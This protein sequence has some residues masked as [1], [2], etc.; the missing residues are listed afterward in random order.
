MKPDFCV[1]EH[2]LVLLKPRLVPPYGWAGHIPFAYLAIDLL[3][4][5]IMVE[6]G[7]HSGNSYMAFCQA[8]QALDLD[9]RCT[10]VDAWQGD[11]HA[12]HYGEEVYQSLRA[13]HDPRYG[14]FSRLLR[15]RFGEAVGQ[16]ADGSI[17]LLHIDGLHTYEAVHHD[18][19]TWLPKLSE[20][21]VVLLHD[22]EERERDFGVGCFFD[23]LA[24]RYPCFAFRHSHGLG[25]VAVGTQL[26][27]AFAAFMRKVADAPQV[28]R[29]FF[30]ALASNLVDADDHLVGSTLAEAQQLSCHLFYRQR[31]ESFDESRMISLPLDAA[32]GVLDLQFRLP[33][34]ATPDYLRIDPADHPGVYELSRVALRQ[35]AD[36]DWHELDGLPSRLGHVHGEL[37]PAQTA[38][39]LRLV[40]FDDDPNLELEVGSA[41]PDRRS[42]EWLDVAVRV[43]YDVVIDDPAL[44]RLLECQ[45]ESLSGMVRLSRERIDVQ[46][47]SREFAGQKS[48]L[49]SL[50]G[51]FGRQRQALQ[52]HSSEFAQQRQQLQSLMD[53]FGQQRQALQDHSLEFAERRQ[54]LQHLMLGFAHQREQLQDLADTLGQQQAQLAEA[55][56]AKAEIEALTKQSVRQQADT[57]A[58]LQRLQQGIDS[59]AAQGFVAR[60]RR[61]LGRGR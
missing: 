40:S 4:P 8:V 27:E 51:E 54:Q 49:Q 29:D 37:L 11:A 10:A 5:R 38:L 61:L 31:D 16:F 33:A 20:R 21:A 59:L 36:D 56:S 32:D 7:T 43:E 30:A 2:P 22:T 47:L 3:R 35:Q 60:M 34:G 55:L 39:C 12:L 52:G 48:Q 26:P 1:E 13:R 53:E 18:F 41:L 25:V 58:A 28:V 24:T 42:G 6:L 14:E 50:A 45:S 15:A 9:C 46:N 57:E 44:Q 17:D 19:E 23:E